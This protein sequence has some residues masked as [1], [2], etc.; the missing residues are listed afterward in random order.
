MEHFPQAQAQEV[1]CSSFIVFS[2]ALEASN[3]G[4]SVVLKKSL[5]LRPFM[6]TFRKHPCVDIRQEDGI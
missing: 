5:S 6:C 4:A 1:A 3:S 2:A